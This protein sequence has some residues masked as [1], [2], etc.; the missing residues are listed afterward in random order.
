MVSLWISQI[1][2]H[3]IG[4]IEDFS[5]AE[6]REKEL[7]Q[8][9]PGTSEY[10]YFSALHSQHMNQLDD[11]DNILK[12]WIKQDGYTPLVKEIMNRQALFRY[13]DK[14][15]K[16]LDYI[17][18]ELNL[19]FDHQKEIDT[20]E[21]LFNSQ[22]DQDLISTKKLT[23][24]TL[25]KYK[26][27]SGFENAGLEILEPEQLNQEQLRHFL[28]RLKQPDIP[29]LAQLVV[30]DLSYK[31]SSG[32]GSH[33]IHK[34]MFKSQL[35][36]CLKL[37]P[38][39]LNNSNF[40]HAFLQKLV[41]PD[42]IDIEDIPAEKK[43]YLSRLWHFSQNLS[44]SFN[45]LKAHILFWLLDFNRRQNN[46]DYNLFW[47]YLAFPRHSSYMK[48]TYIDRS[49]YYVD[50]TEAFENLSL[51][52]PIHSDEEL[53]KDYLFHF[54]KDKDFYYYQTIGAYLDEEWVRKVFAESKIVNMTGDME[55]WYAMISQQEYQALKDRVD[56]DFACSNQAFFSAKDPVTLS[57]YIKNV[58]TLMIKIYEINSLN[59]YQTYHKEPDTT[60]NLDGLSALHEKIVTYDHPPFLRNLETFTFSEINKPGIFVVD[61]IGNG[62]NSRALI[63]KGKLFFTERIGPQGH[64][65]KIFDEKHRRKT[66]AVIKFEGY[67][68]KPD[69]KGIITIPYTTNPIYQKLIIQDNQFCSF[70]GFDHLS[71]EYELKVGFYVDRESLLSG[72]T[73]KVLI[74]PHLMLN[75]QPISTLILKDVKLIIESSDAYGISTTKVIPSFDLFED[76]ESMY[77]FRVPENLSRI[78][79]A[80]SASIKNISQNKVEKLLDSTEFDLNGM[81]QT[82]IFENLLLNH[83]DNTYT[84]EVLGKNGEPRIHR[85][86]DI[87]LKHKYFQDRIK[88][89]LQ[90]DTKGCI[91]LGPLDNIEWI[92]ASCTDNQ[93]YTWDLI[94]SNVFYP[95][96]INGHTQDSIQIP[97]ISPG[98]QPP[99]VSLFEKRGTG[100]Y[101]D[102]RHAITCQQGYIQ[103]NGLS[104]G[105]Y[106][107]FIK[108]E[109]IHITI[110]IDDGILNQDIL[111]AEHR[112]LN[113]TANKAVSIDKVHM[114]HDNVYIKLGN[115]TQF[116]R[117]HAVA[118]KYL[119]DYDIFNHLLPSPLPDYQKQIRKP[120]SHYTSARS[121]GDEYRYILERKYADKYPGNMLSKPGLLLNPWS[122]GK[123]ETDIQD[124]K[125]GE[126][127]K[128]VMD[129]SKTARGFGGGRPINIVDIPKINVHFSNIDFLNQPSL[130]LFN[131]KSDQK[132]VITIKRA[133]LK[134]YRHLH[135]LAVDPLNS[136]YQEISLPKIQMTT[137][138]LRLKKALDAKEHFTQQKR[139]SIVSQ[140]ET[141]VLPDM[142]TSSLEIY[143]TIEK[144]YALLRTLSK[145]GVLKEFEFIQQWQELSLEEKQKHYSEKACHELNFFLYHKDSAFFKDVIYPYINNKKDKTFMDHW[146][147]GDDLT[148]YAD[149]WSFSHLNIAEKILLARRGFVDKENILR[150]VNDLFDMIVPDIDQYNHLFDI[151]LKGKSMD[152]VLRLWKAP[153]SVDFTHKNLESLIGFDTH[154]Q[155]DPVHLS[156]NHNQNKI[157]SYFITRDESKSTNRPFFKK[158]DKT[159]EWAEN[160]YF[161][162][163]QKDQLSDLIK[164][165]AFWKDFAANDPKR[166]FHSKNFIYTT[167][168]FSEMM[169]A[170]SVLDLPF[171]ADK[172]KVDLTGDTFSITAASPMIIFHKEILQGKQSEKNIPILINQHFFRADD[173][174]IYIKNERV[175]KPVEDEFLSGVPYGSQ[176]VVSN[177]SSSNRKLVVM[178]QIPEGAIPIKKGRYIEGIPVTLKPFSTKS[179]EYHFYFPNPGIFAAYP[180]Q[181]AMD[182]KFIAS[183][184]SKVCKVV[185]SLSIIDTQSWKYISQNGKDNDVINFLQQ[186]NLNR[187][188]LS[189]IAFRMKNRMF[190]EQIIHLLKNRHFFHPLLWS[191]GIHHKHEKIISEYLSHSNFVKNCGSFIRSPLLTINPIKRNL[192]E[193]LEYAPLV[194]ARAHRLGKEQVILN[195]RFLKQYQNFLKVLS[196]HPELTAEDLLAITS[197]LLTQDR[198]TQAISFF[199]RINPQKI[200]SK[201]QYDY[202]QTYLLMFQG[203]TN[204]AEKLIQ[205]YLN[206]PVPRWQKL[207]LAVSSQIDEIKGKT[208]TI[209]DENN[210]EQIQGQLAATEESFDFEIKSRQIKIVY[211][212]MSKCQIKYYP[213]DIELLFSRNPFVQKQADEFMII[214]PMDSQTI[215]LPEDKTVHSV[216]LP[217][218]YHNSNLIIEL[219]ANGKRKSHV[220]Y[221]N[222]LHLQVIENYGQ[223]RLTHAKK[224]IPLSK[225]YVKVYSQTKDK[226]VQ[227]HKDGYTDLRGCFDYVSLNTEQLDTIEKFAIL[228]IDEKYGAVTREVGVPKR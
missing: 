147:I 50:L 157:N 39:L 93:P 205:A 146:L 68:F 83:E 76:R 118:T 20:Q 42:H 72:M 142:K 158:L 119:P 196:Y 185:Q 201:I 191:Y 61:F 212:Q 4:F 43:A 208:R 209:I 141:L 48:K 51:F 79:F 153:L 188:D 6:N 22:L 9:I 202:I 18:Q 56:I 154:M 23:E 223:L 175:D 82:D 131:L 206:Y 59:Y 213:M 133:H 122:I 198:I 210:R 227:F 54:F 149:L 120:V 182:E 32:F 13:P 197:Y 104:P 15:Q 12:K 192:Y 55:E 127:R 228:V 150:Y 140:N 49:Y 11:V 17:E 112:A 99:L 16:S 100:W 180:V 70:S 128:I 138:D 103:I 44:Q 186:N 164:V 87:S 65:F 137:R 144:V 67:E 113:I 178:Y 135:L 155:F 52:P 71:E 27:L 24:R 105:N 215:A 34:L 80:L 63:R 181:L 90:T 161:N 218:K 29:G 195:D 35:D 173:R 139:I 40:V 101:S 169:L 2:A 204:D 124:I 123:T 117:L 166:P 3:E 30:N 168:N 183:T 172:H 95:Q 69:N 14:P 58:Q 143:D 10:Y 214:Q 167:Q 66:N 171:Q 194:N 116:T 45:S 199:N 160:N 219:T 47:K 177:P 174:Y 217:R 19:R 91:Q 62:K 25:S 26:N 110:C 159:K 187:L 145:N 102:C 53:L 5:L 97:Y 130:M 8:L 152:T 114:D 163:R 111:V 221:A 84:L 57:L 176:V 75:N 81:D 151:A 92:K 222:S 46:Y 190:F 77:E 78:H 121:I 96:T 184:T 189:K 148:S 98:N 109:N 41:P 7:Q 125:P 203:K 170:L 37:S 207:F 165:N 226:A 108:P 220:C 31:H 73:S 225:A 89:N 179:I 129:N 132:G 211:Q 200:S 36:E 38:N 88:V 115:C 1:N 60:I 33:D 136:V 156:W 126:E 107:L 85:S 74:R 64:E 193:H 21:K 134:L 224:Q 216:D 28:K 86:V 162:I 106:D 94:R